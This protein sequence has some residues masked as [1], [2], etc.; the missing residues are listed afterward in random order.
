MPTVRSKLPNNLGKDVRWES[1]RDS[2][3]GKQTFHAL[4]LYQPPRGTAKQG[5]RYPN[6]EEHQCLPNR[7]WGGGEGGRNINNTGESSNNKIN[8]T[9]NRALK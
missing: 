4:L 3:E 1:L 9:A 6:E 2:S 7:V 8:I 5:N